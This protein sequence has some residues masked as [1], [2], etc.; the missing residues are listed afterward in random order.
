MF[1]VRE[2]VITL[3]RGIAIIHASFTL[4]HW[5]AVQMEEDVLGNVVSILVEQC[6]V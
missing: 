2:V 1:V 6:G 4:V 3:A 5:D